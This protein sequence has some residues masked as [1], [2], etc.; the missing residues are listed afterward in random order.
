MK[1]Y[2][3]AMDFKK[4][5]IEENENVWSKTVKPSFVSING[6]NIKVSANP[7]AMED[8]EHGLVIFHYTYTVVTQTD[9]CMVPLFF[10]SNGDVEDF[11]EI[12]GWKLFFDKPITEFLRCG[13]ITCHMTKGSLNLDIITHP[14]ALD[15]EFEKVWHLFSIVRTCNTQKEID[16]VYKI[17][18]KDK[19]I[20]SLKDKNLKAEAKIEALEMLLDAHKDLIDKLK[21]IVNLKSL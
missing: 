2:D 9:S 21:E 19:D 14:W 13:Y 17:Y 11:I 18:N 6:D 20:L 8:A 16:Y 5:F 3:I 4:K 1:R 12:E 7:Y 15:E 10:N